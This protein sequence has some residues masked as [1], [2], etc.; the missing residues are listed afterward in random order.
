MRDDLL[1][2]WNRP[3]APDQCAH[4]IG[5]VPTSPRGLDDRVANL[6]GSVRDEASPDLADDELVVGALDEERPERRSGTDVGNYPERKLRRVVVS[7]V[8]ILGPVTGEDGS[9]GVCA[10]RMKDDR[11]RSGARRGLVTSDKA[12]LS[13]GEVV[14]H[15]RATKPAPDAARVCEWQQLS[16]TPA[17]ASATSTP[18]SASTARSAS[19]SGAGSTLRPPTTSTSACRATATG[20]S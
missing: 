3:R 6:D 7:D 2:P 10:D 11:S 5:C 18:R 14:W 20:W 16:S 19:R 4:G 1:D 8:Y 13:H 9:G 15:E 12:T 17:S